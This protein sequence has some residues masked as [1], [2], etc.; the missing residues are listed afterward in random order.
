MR[1]DGNVDDRSETNNG[2]LIRVF[3]NV[4]FIMEEFLNRNA[5]CTLYF[6]GSTTQRT[7]VYNMILKRYHLKFSEKYHITAGVIVDSECVEIEFNPFEIEVYEA[8]LVRKK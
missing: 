7:V 6:A 8:F 1:P 5:D 2:D 4:I 3:S